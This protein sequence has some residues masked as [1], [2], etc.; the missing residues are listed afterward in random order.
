VRCALK[1][2][3]AGLICSF[4]RTTSGPAVSSGLPVD[5]Y[6]AGQTGRKMPRLVNLVN[7]RRQKWTDADMTIVEDSRSK[8][9][10]T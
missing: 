6:H 9:Y 2:N 7:N 4:C 5:F 1:A 10:K 8:R 3:W